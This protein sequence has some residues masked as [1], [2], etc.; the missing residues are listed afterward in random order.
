[1]ITELNLVRLLIEGTPKEWSSNT[2]IDSQCLHYSISMFALNFFEYLRSNIT[3]GHHRRE[4]FFYANEISNMQMQRLKF[5]QLVTNKEAYCWT[6]F[7]IAITTITL[8][9]TI[10]WPNHYCTTLLK[11]IS[12]CAIKNRLLDFLRSIHILFSSS[13]LNCTTMASNNTFTVYSLKQW[14]ADEKLELILLLS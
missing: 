8:F 12:N 3:T 6:N 7:A 2:M 10:I 4:V 1:M 9:V 5:I 11:S 14:F 13:L